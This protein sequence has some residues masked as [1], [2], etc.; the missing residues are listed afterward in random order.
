M[1]CRAGEGHRSCGAAAPEGSR[2]RDV[3]WLKMLA[4]A[5]IISEKVPHALLLDAGQTHEEE[6][7]ISALLQPRPAELF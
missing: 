5:V 6:R 1:A 4:A 3:S 7:S 2:L